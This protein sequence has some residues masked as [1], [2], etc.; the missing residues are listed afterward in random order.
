[1]CLSSISF[2]FLSLTQNLIEHKRKGST[3]KSIVKLQPHIDTMTDICGICSSPVAWYNRMEQPCKKHVFHRDCFTK[4]LE[5]TTLS[6]EMFR[7]PSCPGQASA[8]RSRGGNP[9]SSFYED[10]KWTKARGTRHPFPNQFNS[11][12]ASQNGIGSNQFRHEFQ[13]GN[14]QAHAAEHMNSFYMNQG[15]YHPSPDSVI[16]FNDLTRAVKSLS[17]ENQRLYS[18]LHQSVQEKERIHQSHDEFIKSFRGRKTQQFD[19]FE[20]P[21][22]GMECDFEEDVKIATSSSSSSSSSDVEEV[23][24]ASTRSTRKASNAKTSSKT[25]SSSKVNLECIKGPHKGQSFL[26]TKTLILGKGGTWKE[27]VAD[28]SQ[29]L[30]VCPNHAKLTLVK[31]G[32]KSKQVLMVEVVDLKSKNGTKVKNKKLVGS[33]KRMA[34]VNDTITVGSSVLLISKTK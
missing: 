1:M 17:E 2:E 26:L 18:L 28:L 16:Q 30:Y 31:K 7:C 25:S 11:F 20:T 34:F 10:V 22:E 29:D 23:K 6:I 8:Q 9:S 3:F 19:G 15:M 27:P 13:E 21:S 4:R 33:T 14:R 5:S 24:T 32:P 12:A